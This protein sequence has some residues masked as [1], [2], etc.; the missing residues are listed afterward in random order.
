VE[1]CWR[2][3]EAGME[4]WLV[5]DAVFGHACARESARRP[6]RALW[7]HLRSMVRFF[8]DHPSALFR[9]DREDGTLEA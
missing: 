4:V 7:H 3:R 1:W 8:S 2:A 5:P 9:A 6:G